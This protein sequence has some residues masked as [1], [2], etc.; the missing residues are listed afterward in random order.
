MR[1]VIDIDDD[2]LDAAAAELGTTTKRDT[3]NAALAYVADRRRRTAL[4]D[5]PLVWGGSD[6]TDDEVM[7]GARR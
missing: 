2:A 5:N 4:F 3:V 1:T 6:L 7:A